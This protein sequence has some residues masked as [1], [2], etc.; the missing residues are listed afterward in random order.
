[1]ICPFTGDQPFWAERMRSVGVAPDPVPQR[2][3]TAERLVAA[4]EATTSDARTAR[5]AAEIGELVRSEDGARRAVELLLEL[6]THRAG[7][8]A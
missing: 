4:V 1:V 6:T 3:I 7:R 2:L 8:S 5:R